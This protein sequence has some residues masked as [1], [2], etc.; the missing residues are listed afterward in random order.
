MEKL[1]VPYSAQVTLVIENY[2]EIVWFSHAVQSM[3]MIT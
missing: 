3:T 2:N 1:L